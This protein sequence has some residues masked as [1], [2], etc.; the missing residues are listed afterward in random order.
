M[1]MKKSSG[2]LLDRRQALLGGAAC[3]ASAALPANAQFKTTTESLH[4]SVAARVRALIQGRKLSLRLL[5]PHGSGGNVG[6]VAQ[7]FT[8]MTGVEIERVET[9]VDEINTQLALDVFSESQSYDVALPAT[10]GLPDLVA[11][12][13]I[14]SLTDFA[15]QYE[16]KGFRDNILFGTGDSFDGEIY[17]FQADGD[18]YVMFYHKDLLE[19]PDEQARYADKFGTPL[20][21]PNIWQELDR[22]MA[23]FHRPE[24]GMYGGLLFRAPSFLAWEWWIRFHAKGLWPFAEDMTPQ[25]ASDE[26][27]CALED[28]IRAS[29]YLSPEAPNLGLFDNWERYSRGNVY[30]NIG[31]GGSQKYLNGPSSKMRGS[32][33]YGPTPGG[34]INGKLLLTPYFNWG[35]N[36]V[37]VSNSAFPE[38]AYLF[39]LFASSPAMSTLAVGQVD[40]FFD[41]YRPEHYTDPGIQAAYTPE[42]LNVHRDSMRAAI[43]DLY[44][45]NQGEY[46]RVLKLWLARAIVGEE[47]PEIA[48]KQVSDR[49]Q[50][51]TRG[52]GRS[53]QEKRWAELRAKY[54]KATRDVLRDLS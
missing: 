27:V 43:P 14:Q 54:P 37:V 1:G 26:G 30:C 24:Q 25:I 34:M 44:L 45:Q 22:Q 23:F 33:V 10:F 50:I 13:A 46:F 18:A 11:S 21:R 16:P 2:L 15:N 36:Y 51:I 29:Q 38:I 8:A 7:A 5:L 48:L 28:M 53:L 49:W 19:N 6:P 41:P 40:G 42:F 47:K 39:A 4:E 31:W 32:I 17:G 12:G 35:W 20:A 9:P 52:A 3:A